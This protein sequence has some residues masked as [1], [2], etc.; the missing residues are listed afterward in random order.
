MTCHGDDPKRD[1]RESYSRA[2]LV[3]DVPGIVGHEDAVAPGWAPRVH[4][5]CGFSVVFTVRVAAKD[6]YDNVS[7]GAERTNSVNTTLSASPGQRL[8]RKT[9]VTWEETE[10]PLL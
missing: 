8:P 4:V 10:S 6:R 1:R 5:L 7:I 2:H 3:D 9:R